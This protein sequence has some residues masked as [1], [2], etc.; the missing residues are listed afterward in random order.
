M[1]NWEVG[2][3]YNLKLIRSTDRTD[4]V[5]FSNDENVF[6]MMDYFNFLK[7]VRLKEHY[8]GYKKLCGLKN[9]YSQGLAYQNIGIY[10]M[11]RKGEP[12]DTDMTVKSS[13]FEVSASD[14]TTDRPFIGLILVYILDYKMKYEG[15]LPE[16]S[17][18]SCDMRRILEN[19]RDTIQ[20]HISLKEKDYSIF[21]T[22]A[23]ADFCVAI[24][25]DMLQDIYNTA[26]DIMKIGNQDHKR[27]FFT[28][29]NV[30]IECG[31][32][33]E[34]KDSADK[35]LSLSS[36]IL[37]KNKDIEFAVRFRI[38]HSVL[39]EM[40]ELQTRMPKAVEVVSGLFGRYDL[41]IRCSM[42]DF[43]EIYPYLYQ[44]KVGALNKIQDI[45]NISGTFKSNINRVL[46]ASMCSGTIRTMNIR[47]LIHIDKGAE[48]DFESAEPW[49]DYETQ[50]E[51]KKDVNYIKQEYNQF[52]DKYKA[53][54]L[55]DKYWYQDISSIFERIINLYEGLAYE[56]DTYLNW[57]VY[58]EYLQTLFNNMNSYMEKMQED[59]Q[60]DIRIFIT[61]FQL[62]IHAFDE[63]IKILQG[64]NQNTLQAPKYDA[65]VPFDG[66]KFLLSYTEYLTQVYEQYRNYPWQKKEGACQEPRRGMKII[67]YPEILE[68]RIVVKELFHYPEKEKEILNEKHE[69]ETGLL[70]CKL[71]AFEYFARIYD[72]IPLITH[73]ICHQMLILDRKIRNEFYLGELFDRVSREI[74]CSLMRETGSKKNIVIYDDLTQTFQKNLAECLLSQYLEEHSGWEKYTFS[75]IN[76]SVKSFLDDYIRIQDKNDVFNKNHIDIKE[77]IRDFQNFIFEINSNRDEHLNY[78]SAVQKSYETQSRLAKEGKLA[79][80]EKE[81]NEGNKK[82]ERL[83]IL[84]HNCIS[85]SY[86]NE[87][88]DIN[89][90]KTVS[91]NTRGWLGMDDYLC[92]YYNYEIG[93]CEKKEEEQQLKYYVDSVRKLH[94]LYTNLL[95]YKPKDYEKLDRLLKTYAGKLKKVIEGSYVQGERYASYSQDKIDRVTYLGIHNISSSTA[96]LKDFFR[97]FDF[98]NIEDTIKRTAILYRESCADII[99]CRFLGFTGFGYFRMSVT[100]WTRMEHNDDKSISTSYL[101]RQRLVA[102]LMV[103]LS[104]ED[105]TMLIQKKDYY[106]YKICHLKEEIYRYVDEQLKYAEGRIKDAV[107]R[108]LSNEEVDQTQKTTL[109]NECEKFFLIF[110]EN[111]EEMKKNIEESKQVFWEGGIWDALCREKHRVFINAKIIREYLRREVNLYTRVIS[112]LC[113]LSEIQV[114][115][116][117]EIDKEYFEHMDSIYSVLDEEKELHPVVRKVVEFYNTTDSEGKTDNEEKMKD[118][119]LFMQDHYFYN[120]CKNVWEISE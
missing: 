10:R 43:Y 97:T 14:T 71:P 62:F 29:T 41:V 65:V 53:R 56:F 57:R 33:K 103:L 37:E 16:Q 27:V 100:F 86:N 74:S 91:S 40:R 31:K 92:D 107:I 4:N 102:V 34:L 15:V 98:T 119:L 9:E 113:M 87:K 42:A 39:Q 26:T 23:G 12:G 38:E 81:R 5:T 112:I 25:T 84:L 104:K 89:R 6:F 78:L 36:H 8:H 76:S 117:I 73:E 13:M 20:S 114:N 58:K 70:I 46:L 67:I 22:I 32:G 30:G 18:N 59:N 19:Y 85:S 69:S 50:E 115:G 2:E 24:R 21:Q 94:I 77:L 55:M 95:E 48:K 108:D 82:L 1:E 3:V 45:E 79:E 44:N 75:Y 93:R 49:F 7:S 64:V 96:A 109:V 118:M 51:I 90:L 60:R 105:N 120:R 99:M 28:Y 68:N 54:F 111:I 61:E 66:Q 88:M 110:R 35:F 17:Y 83:Y 101:Q 52:Q 106:Q 63:Y 116:S 72:M 11:K 80:A 47:V